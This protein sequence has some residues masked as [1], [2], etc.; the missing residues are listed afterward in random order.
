MSNNICHECG[1]E[2][3]PQYVYCKNCGTQLKD[4]PDKKSKKYETYGGT[5]YQNT[6]RYKKNY[7][8][9]YRESVIDSI[10]G[11][12]SDD[13]IVF[14]GKKAYNIVP[15]F[16]KMELANTKTSWCWPAAILGYF[17]GPFGAAIWFFYRKMYKLAFISTA[18]GLAVGL[19][20]AF[21]AGDNNSKTFEE[22]FQSGWMTGNYGSMFDEV[23][24]TLRSQDTVRMHIVN[25]ANSLISIA[26]MI[27]SG[28]FSYYFYKLSVI[29]SIRKYQNTNVDPRYYK[30]GLASLGG[31]ST[32]M[33]IIGFVIMI[34]SSELFSL[35]VRLF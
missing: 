26:T 7:S 13:V 33:A 8:N 15:K 14:V 4:E 27:I 32:G 17:F 12:D 2:N 9:T 19:V 25:T 6:G 35:I 20:L 5:A 34:F 28:I 10:G 31:T 23:G 30:M 16:S 1:T 11:V 29:K 22:I 18:I 21:V 3:E 24:N